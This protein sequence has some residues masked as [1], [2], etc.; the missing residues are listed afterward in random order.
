MTDDWTCPH[1]FGPESQRGDC[2]D[3]NR[4]IEGRRSRDD[5][6]GDERAE[7]V[8]ALLHDPSAYRM[9]DIH[10]RL[11]DL[12][13]RPVWTHE[14]VTD[15]W[16]MEKARGVLPHPKDLHQ[17]ALE[18]LEAIADGKPIIVVEGRSDD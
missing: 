2:P 7:E 17:H 3:C 9:D 16:L 12:V 8:R 5:M 18:S 15:T 6:T 10:K 14:F 4:D 1:G 13:G 11:E